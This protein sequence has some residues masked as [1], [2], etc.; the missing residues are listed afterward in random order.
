MDHVRLWR[1][2][3]PRIVFVAGPTQGWRTSWIRVARESAGSDDLDAAFGW[4]Y[5]HAK[6]LARLGAIGEA[7]QLAREALDLVAQTDALNRH[8]DSL[9]VLAEIFRRRGRK[10]EADAQ[11]REAL[12]LYEQKG[13]VVSAERAK[14][15]LLEGAIPE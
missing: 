2:N 11:I 4:R 8:G 1:R 5:V 15:L 13:N 3:L 14:A 6:V 9:L 10:N 12:R 7:E